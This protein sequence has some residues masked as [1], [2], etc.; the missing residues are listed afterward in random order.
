[1]V[2]IFEDYSRLLLHLEDREAWVVDTHHLGCSCEVAPLDDRAICH[3]SHVSHHAVAGCRIL[4]QILFEVQVLFVVFRFCHLFTQRLRYQLVQLKS[5]FGTFLGFPRRHHCPSQVL[6]HFVL[7]L[8]QLL[9]GIMFLRLH[10]EVLRLDLVLFLGE[11]LPP[12]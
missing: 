6:R 1:M 11:S 9:L 2:R 3:V 8:L 10:L 4:L 5:F 7:D 12:G